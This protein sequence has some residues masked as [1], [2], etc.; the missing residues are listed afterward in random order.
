MAWRFVISDLCGGIYS[1][2]GF[3]IFWFLVNWCFG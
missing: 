1:S 3:L 2:G